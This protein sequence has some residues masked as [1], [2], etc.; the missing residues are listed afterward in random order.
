M[1]FA[2]CGLCAVLLISFPMPP[3]RSKG[4]KETSVRAKSTKSPKQKTPINSRVEVTK[5]GS[6]KQ[7][8]V[9]TTLE[10]AVASLTQ[11]R[12][13]PNESCGAPHKDNESAS[14]SPATVSSTRTTV[15]RIQPR[16]APPRPLASA[17]R[18]AGRATKEQKAVV[19][20]NR[21]T[22]SGRG[23]QTKGHSTSPLDAE[24]LAV[25]DNT[26]VHN[27][28]TIS[29]SSDNK[30]KRKAVK[31]VPSVCAECKLSKIVW[32]FCGLTGNSHIIV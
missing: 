17:S 6:G 19:K 26:T 20:S 22:S 18:S 8:R 5:G 13:K 10:M 29:E 4:V 27:D 3:K 7:S 30:S 24:P 9:T 32:P 12:K 11:Q 28:N 23:K 16:Q 21:K 15:A 25:I 14:S 31:K 1:V 2:G